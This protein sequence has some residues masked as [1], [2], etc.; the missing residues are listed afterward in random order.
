MKARPVA[1]EI[2]CFRDVVSALR[3][4]GLRLLVTLVLILAAGCYLLCFVVATAVV[5]IVYAFAVAPILTAAFVHVPTSWAA[6][7]ATDVVLGVPLVF[8]NV[9]GMYWVAGRL[10]RPKPDRSRREADQPLNPPEGTGL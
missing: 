1:P 7:F 5:T 9:R 10:L 3:T 8:A 6:E 4:P 2:T